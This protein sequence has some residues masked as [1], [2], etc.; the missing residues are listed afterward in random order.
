MWERYGDGEIITTKF[1]NSRRFQIKDFAQPFRTLKIKSLVHYPIDQ[2]DFLDN[3]FLNHKNW[4]TSICCRFVLR[5]HPL[6]LRIIT[7]DD[8]GEKYWIISQITT[9]LH[10]S[11]LL[12]RGEKYQHKFCCFIFR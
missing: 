8:F 4:A 3:L 10:T 1:Q 6:Y 11:I 7:S 12:M 2:E 9:G 5:V